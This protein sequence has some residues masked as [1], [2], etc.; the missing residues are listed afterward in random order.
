MTKVVKHAFVHPSLRAI[1]TVE[2]K[3]D[4]YVERSFQNTKRMNVGSG[5][6]HI[7]IL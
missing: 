4:N 7:V 6:E 5:N 2:T 3:V 1:T